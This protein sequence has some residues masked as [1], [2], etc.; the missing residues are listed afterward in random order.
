[1]PN[2]KK[3]KISKIDNAATAHPYSRKATQLRR[4]LNRDD[5]LHS[6]KKAGDVKKTRVVDRMLWFKYALDDNLVAATLEHAHEIVRMYIGRHDAEIDELVARLRKGRPPPGRLELLRNLRAKDQQEYNNGIEVPNLTDPKNVVTL[7]AW[8]GDYNGLSHIKSIVLR[9]DAAA[10]ANTAESPTTAAA[11]SAPS[12]KP[13][14]AA[15]ATATGME[16][17]A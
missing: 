15:I 13:L 17:D 2:N 7:K 14:E 9:A 6:Q 11:A 10:A 12:A 1:M 16:V 4:A 5:K 8:E 3:K